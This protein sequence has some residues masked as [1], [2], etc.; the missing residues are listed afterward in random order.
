MT[1]PVERVWQL[2]D[3][4]SREDQQ[5]AGVT[6]RLFA[7]ATGDLAVEWLTSLLGTPEGIDRLESFVGKFARMQDT[8]VDKLLP[9]FARGDR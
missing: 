3:L 7:T 5:L 4:V 1:D 2:L 6:A 9:R 8:I